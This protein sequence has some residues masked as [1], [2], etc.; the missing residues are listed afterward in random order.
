MKSADSSTSEMDGFLQDLADLGQPGAGLT[1]ASARL[2]PLPVSTAERSRL[3]AA[4]DPYERFARFERAVAELLRISRADAAAAL[5]RIDDPSAWQQQGPGLEYL[6]VPGG[7]GSDF[8]L[9]GLLRLKAGLTFPE[10]EHLGEEL[11]FVLQGAL[12]DSVSHAVFGPGQPSRMPAGSR[13][14]FR[15]PA[16]GP[17]LVGLV[18]VQTGIRLVF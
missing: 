10:H 8:F 3:L 13:H 14:S 1:Y 5:R 2:A 17:D 11:T 18:T 4:L 9:S 12:E 15:V 7:Q 6:A 16:G